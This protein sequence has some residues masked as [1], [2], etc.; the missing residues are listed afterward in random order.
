MDR[1]QYILTVAI[2]A[3][4]FAAVTMIAIMLVR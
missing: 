4:V 2:A 3:L 1:V